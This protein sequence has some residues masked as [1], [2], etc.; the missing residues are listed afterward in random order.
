MPETRP[1]KVLHPGEG[2]SVQLGPLFGVDF[3]FFSEDTGGLVSVVEHP[4][5]PGA[6]VPPHM[7]TREDEYSIVIEGEI[8]F[9]SGDKEVTLSP[10]GYITKPRGELHTM[11]NAATFPGRIIEIIT[12]G[13]FEHFFREAD[14]L[15]GSP[16][17]MSDP[18]ALISLGARY[19]LTYD[20]TWV[21]ELVAK[22]GLQPMG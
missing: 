20:N 12:P 8:S 21:P 10:G 13:G 22:H 11:W 2:Q 17:G 16:G 18:S 5:A 9:R 6:L 7:H 14:E 15:F 3:K 4:F 19:G 1:F